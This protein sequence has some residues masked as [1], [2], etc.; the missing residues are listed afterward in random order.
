MTSNEIISAW[1]QGVPLEQLLVWSKCQ[2][3]SE[4]EKWLKK[5]GECYGC[6]K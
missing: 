5:Q 2:T 3:E 4:F 1:K 6:Q